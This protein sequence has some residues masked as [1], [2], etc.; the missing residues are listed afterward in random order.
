MSRYTFAFL[1]V[2][3]GLGASEQPANLTGDWQL[4]VEKSDWGSR[5]KPVSVALHIDHKEPALT[6]SGVVIY[7]GEDTRTFS[8]AGAIDGKPYDMVRSFGPGTV[9]LRRVGVSTVESVFRTRDN[10]SVETTRTTL[11]PNGRTLTRRMRLQSPKGVS[12]STEVYERH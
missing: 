1:F 11:L 4:S 7:S 12:T 5:P 8:F 6:Y 9:V 2:A 10:T 3:L